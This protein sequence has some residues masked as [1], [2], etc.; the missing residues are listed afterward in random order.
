LIAAGIEAV[1]EGDFAADNNATKLSFKTGASEA[2][3]EKMALSSAGVL[4]IPADG[5]G[6]SSSS[7]VLGAGSD[8]QIFHDG[9]NSYINE[10]GDGALI[11]KGSTV[12]LQ[13][14]GAETMV[15][16]ATDGAVTLYYDNAAKLATVTGGVTVTGTLTATTVTETSDERLKSDI[17]IIEN[18]LDKVMNMRGVRF[19]RDNEPH[20]GV[21]AQEVE[22]I[23]PEVVT[24][25]DY[26][27]VAYGNMVGVLIEAVKDLKKE[28]DE[29]KKGCTCG[30]NN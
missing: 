15:N 9:S 21:I 12:I 8:L 10:T 28:L 16:A 20:I 18:G 26:K 3:T 13:S 1:S 19:T 6:T 22:K 27:S 24:D 17:K 4:S 30:S 23:I 14:S 11:L 29:H 25:G 2:A 7:I 5:S